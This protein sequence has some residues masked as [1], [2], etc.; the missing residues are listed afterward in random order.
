MASEWPTERVS[1]LQRKG[2]L[3]VEDGNHGE[4][5]PR[6][7]E[8]VDRGV[9]FIRAADME[10]G[11]V[12]FDSASKINGRAR[13]RITKGIGAPGDVLLSHKGTVGKVA[14]VADD[15]PP[16][17]CSPQTTFWRTLNSEL[18]DR[19]Y[20]YAFLRSS[21]FHAQLATRASETDMAPYV[22]LTS[23]RGLSVLVPPI[24][25]QRA[26]A[27]ILGTLDDK[28]ELNRRMNDT[29]EVIARAIF[30]SWFVNFDP[31]RAKA[32]GRNLELPQFLADLFPDNFEHSELGE[33]PEGWAFETLSDHFEAVKGVSYKGSGLGN[34]GMPLHNLNSVYEGG[35]YKY[36]GIKYYS[37]E[38]SERHIVRP[39]DVIV[40]NTEQGHDRLLI[41][42]AAIVPALFGERGI[43]SHHIYRLRPKPR[44]PLTAAFLCHLL[45]S[46][47]MH[48]VVSR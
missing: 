47:Q 16:F 19:K 48:D 34:S 17:V 36:E 2:I 37:G 11:V 4:Y 44:S 5:R 3:L 38:Y 40:A 14:L 35:G 26:I 23:Q 45:N 13:Q 15:A 20:L 1:D 31:V 29:L 46:Q 39:G 43:A 28:I 32:E 6:P 33:I 24:S 12:L 8:F 42:Y 25:E 10:G 30:Q 9:A 22:S 21:L 7:D 41:G 18:L 27:H